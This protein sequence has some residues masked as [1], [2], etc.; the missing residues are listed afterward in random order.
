MKILV[1]ICFLA[2]L[3]YSNAALSQISLQTPFQDCQLEGSITLYD[4]KNQK[5]TYSDEVDSRKETLP[6]S[7]FKIMHSLIALETGVVKDEFEIIKWVGKT[8]TVLYGYRPDIYKDMNM[9]EAFELSSVWVYIEFAKRIDRKKYQ[10]YLQQCGYGNGNLTEKG[11]DF[12]NFGAFGVSPVNQITMLKNLYE[13][14]LPFSKRNQQRV[15]RIML[16]EKTDTYA[17]HAK[18]GWT[19]FNGMDVGWWVGYVETKDNVY[20]FATRVSKPR[21]KPHPN[22][23]SCR[24][25]ITKAVLKEMGIIEK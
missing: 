3:L 23:G 1:F 4:F 11:V 2:F 9:K 21:S 6:A 14:K 10:K 20:F 17:I 5:W 15:K 12:W 8:D 13:E 7:T 25:E 16:A 22:F 19:R 24:K 18:T